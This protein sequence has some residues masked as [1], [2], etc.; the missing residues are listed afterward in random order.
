VLELPAKAEL[1]SLVRLLVSSLA[2]TRRDLTEERV[3]DLRLAVSEACAHAIEASERQ[4]ADPRLSVGWREADDH[5]E[6]SIVDQGGSFDPEAV[7]E[8]QS[9]VP[10]G[11]RGLSVALLRA[12]VDDVVFLSH[13]SG[14]AVHMV[15]YCG[16]AGPGPH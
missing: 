16:R 3:D 2:S 13:E 15:L 4:A 5:L 14:T 11:E 7:P 10:L 6:V 9:G 12:L 1:V 8:T